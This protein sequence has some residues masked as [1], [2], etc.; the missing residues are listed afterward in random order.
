MGLAG[1]AGLADLRKRQCGVLSGAQ[2][3]EY[4]AKS[5]LQW[6]TSPTGRWQRPLPRVIV[7][8]NGPLSRAQQLQAALLYGGPHA[9]LSHSTAASLGGLEGYDDH[10]VHLLL[11]HPSSLP[12]KAFVVVHR[13]RNAP[14]EVNDVHPTRRP[15]RLRLPRALIEMARTAT[16]LE[17]ARAPLA[18]AVQQGLVRPRALREVLVRVGPMQF[19]AQLFAAIDD[20]ELGAHSGLELEFLALIREHSLPEPTLQQRV[21]AGGLRKLDASWPAYDVWVEI[22][23]A[24]HRSD[25]LWH[26][27][28]DRHNEISVSGRR[29]CTLRFSGHQLKTG[30][31]RCGRQLESALRQGG[32]PGR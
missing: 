13:S 1:L 31:A 19:Q 24:A 10:A 3:R 18:A 20:I 9:V 8:H 21:E 15:R 16:T 4:V 5:S 28:L 30:R 7:T 26:A 27:D 23:G 17:D 29:L 11:P 12:S 25:A 14:D 22:D 32:W 6:L 2:A